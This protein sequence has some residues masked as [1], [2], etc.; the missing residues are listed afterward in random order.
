MKL[1]TAC[2]VVL[3]AVMAPFSTHAQHINNYGTGAISAGTTTSTT[4]SN[5]TTQTTSTKQVF[6]GSQHTVTGT[7]IQSSGT[8]Q[9]GQPYTI[10]E[11]GASFQFS[12]TYRPAGLTSIEVIQSTTD[13][14]TTTNQL[15]VFTRSGL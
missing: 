15:S 4:V 8:I 3:G 5:S 12:E 14:T 13:T 1:P 7:N 6:D 10:K 11:Q 9:P 2:A